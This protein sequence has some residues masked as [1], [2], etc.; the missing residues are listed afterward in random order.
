[1]SR[2]P[3][4]LGHRLDAGRPLTVLVWLT[5]AVLVIAPVG[6]AANSPLLAG[7][8][9]AYI[10]SGIAGVSALALLLLQPLLAAGYL[11]G[12][13]VKQERRWHRW[14]G[15]GI[16]FAV[17]LH[18]GGL[19]VTSPPDTIDALLLVSP[20]LFS[21][22]GVVGLW[23]LILTAIFVAMRLRISMRY[24]IWRIIHNGLAVVVVVSSVVHAWM[25]EGTMGGLSKI[26]LCAGV[27]VVTAFVI[28]HLRVVKP[29]QRSR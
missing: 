16:V 12:L 11:P 13:R 22:Y 7:R 2:L 17:L 8:D 6:I 20:T 3:R 26:I 9:I 28:L 14:V 23:S 5:L 18:I 1:M 29:L 25:I 24:G 4:H 21:V 19:Y 15:S 10:V 27:L